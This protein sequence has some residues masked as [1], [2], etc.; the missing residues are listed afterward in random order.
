MAKYSVIE[1]SVR[2]RQLLGLSDKNKK[3]LQSNNT[4]YIYRGTRSGKV[5]IG[6]TGNFL[7]RQSQH[8]SG[9]E[10]RFNNA[11][12][13]KVLVI[14]SVYFN[15]SALDDVESQLITYFAADNPKKQ[16]AVS[17]DDSIVTNLTGGNTVNQY[18]ERE[19]V[20][21]KVILPLWEKELYTRKWVHSPTIEE[22]RAKELVKYSPLKQLTPE[23]DSLINEILN[24]KANY[25]I[26][27]DAGT[28]KTV[29][30]THIVAAFLKAKP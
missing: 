18:K 27:G 7:N 28:G 20:A 10:E 29:L 12:F 17:F 13:D 30:L 14:I 5:Y 26:N 2:N 3:A 4:I 15:K 19:E 21:S 1:L 11:D 23:Q 16:G 22:L 25:V 6:Q 24:S 8:F 9:Q